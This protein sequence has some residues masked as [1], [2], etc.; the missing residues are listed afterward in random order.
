MDA[1][2]GSLNCGNVVGYSYDGRICAPV[3][4]SCEGSE[5]DDMFGSMAECDAAY[6]DC[7][8]TQGVLQSCSGHAS[9]HVLPRTCC[10]SCGV[11]EPDMLIA[12]Y[13]RQMSLNDQCIGDPDAGCPECGTTPNPD[14]SARCVEDTCQLVDLTGQAD[15]QT[16]DDCQ[17]VSKDCCICAED[18]RSG[19][20]AMSKNAG[21]PSFCGNDDCE[22]CTRESDRELAVTCN[23][24]LGK[25]EV[26]IPTL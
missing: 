22:P 8:A 19:F 24:E 18:P 7:Y 6:T 15:C 5:C 2:N 13:S 17:L 12:I 25:C 10:Q 1:H 23:I 3:Y 4:C 26:R 21:R 14:V 16:S 9:C 11:P 20:V